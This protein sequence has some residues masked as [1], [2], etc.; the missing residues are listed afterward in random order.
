MWNAGAEQIP[1]LI[2]RVRFPSLPQPECLHS[3]TR[4][5]DTPG[6]RPEIGNQTCNQDAMLCLSPGETP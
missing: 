3:A 6:D 2:V 5:V 4:S 1:K